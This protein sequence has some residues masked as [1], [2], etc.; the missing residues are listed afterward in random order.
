M[1]EIVSMVHTYDCSPL[2]SFLFFFP[3]LFAANWYSAL[4]GSSSWLPDW[5]KIDQRWKWWSRVTKYHLFPYVIWKNKAASFMHGRLN[6]L[7]LSSHLKTLLP[8]NMISC[9]TNARVLGKKLW[10]T[11]V[12]VLFGRDNEACPLAKTCKINGWRFQRQFGWDRSEV[13]WEG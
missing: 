5:I 3:F 10:D 1:V 9:W 6:R 2:I 11:G 8:S 13:V 7:H 12:L 4:T